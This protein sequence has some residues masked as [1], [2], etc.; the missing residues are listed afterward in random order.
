MTRRGRVV[1]ALFVA[2]L[3]PAFA[4]TP[5]AMLAGGPVI[6]LALGIYALAVDAFVAYPV[7]LVVGVPLYLLARHHEW[8]RVVIYIAGGIAVGG[9][10]VLIGTA[11]MLASNPSLNPLEN[12]PAV[13]AGAVAGGVATTSFWLIARPDRP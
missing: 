9:G 5:I 3:T 12:I 13:V 11:M 2:P 8:T 10:A 4:L 1:A 7:T 6:G